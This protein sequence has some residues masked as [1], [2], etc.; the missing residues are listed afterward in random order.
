[1]IYWFA[2][3]YTFSDTEAETEVT[4]DGLRQSFNFYNVHGSAIVVV[5]VRTWIVIFRMSFLN[6][7]FATRVFATH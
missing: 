1:M 3:V 7:W 2:L 5:H 6:A 4:V